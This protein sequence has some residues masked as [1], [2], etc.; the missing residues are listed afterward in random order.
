MHDPVLAGWCMVVTTNVHGCHNPETWLFPFQKYGCFMVVTRLLLA[1]NNQPILA[2]EQPCFW[3]V[4]WLLITILQRPSACHVMNLVKWINGV[5][6]DKDIVG[7]TRFYS[8][9]NKSTYVMMPWWCLVATKFFYIIQQS[10]VIKIQ[11]QYHNASNVIAA[12]L[13]S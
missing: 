10:S 13:L 5:V 6:I 2:L 8:L 9:L 3:V 1:W 12:I 7:T 11:T 4:T